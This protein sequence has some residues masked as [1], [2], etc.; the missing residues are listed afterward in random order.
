M[1]P[2]TGNNGDVWTLTDA[3][4]GQGAWQPGLAQETGSFAMNFDNGLN[5]NAKYTKVGSLVVLQLQGVAVPLGAPIAYFNSVSLL[6]ESIRP[7]TNIIYVPT[8][9]YDAETSM[10]GIFTIYSS[11]NFSLFRGES[12]DIPDQFVGPESGTVQCPISY[13]IF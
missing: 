6:P 8:L 11:G 10:A 2:G 12:I 3:P 9:V 1:K 4:S 7:I 13:S 5:L